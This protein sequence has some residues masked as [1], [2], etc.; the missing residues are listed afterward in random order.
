MFICFLKKE[1]LFCVFGTSIALSLRT[2]SKE[3][4]V[5]EGGVKTWESR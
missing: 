3:T 5:K 2:K 1:T 4:N